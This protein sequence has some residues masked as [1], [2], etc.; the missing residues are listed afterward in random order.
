MRKES[1]DFAGT[2]PEATDR[3]GIDL[4]LVDVDAHLEFDNH[5]DA[6]DQIEQE[7]RAV[8]SSRY[9]SLRFPDRLE[10]L[11]REQYIPRAIRLFH[12]RVPF[13]FFIFFIVNLGIYQVLEHDAA[14]RFFNINAWTGISILIATVLSFLP[15]TKHWYE[16][17]ISAGGMGAIAVSTVTANMGG[18]DSAVLTYA[19]IVYIVVIIY[20]FLCLRF[21]VATLIGWMGGLIGIVLAYATVH[22]INWKLYGLIFIITN[23]LG[24]CLSYTLDRQERT[25][26][27][28]GYLLQLAA[29]KS[30]R[31]A[32]RLEILSRLDGLT[33]LANRRHLDEMM[34]QE[35]NRGLRQ[36][37]ALTLM[38]IDVD[39]FKN[40]NDQLGHVAGDDCLR[41]I[42]CLLLSLA[43][44]SGELAARYGGEEF[45][46][47][48]PSMDIDLAEQQVQ[49][50]LERLAELKIKNPDENR[51][52]VTVSVGIAV[53]IPSEM[54]SV[55]Q[56][57]RQ[58]DAALYKAKAN[59][60]NRYEFFDDTVRSD[61]HISTV[62]G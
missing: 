51:P 13:L 33:G 2:S 15:S 9:W 49:R 20:S 46:L 59:G 37:Q 47:L 35:W 28:Q 30:A 3:D 36:H 44:R 6:N 5:V 55:E 38:I 8:L 16:W 21:R 11:F 39:F 10:A 17:Y 41:R 29:S 14:M 53:G 4:D 18:G 27:L 52:F 56:L 60:R 26:F 32:R 45:V 23:L 57:L 54:T 50:L 58:A 31:L 43:K 48:F 7:T 25:S 61:S 19:G 34:N 40:Y 22:A 1:T 42:G 24:M 12:F 62:H